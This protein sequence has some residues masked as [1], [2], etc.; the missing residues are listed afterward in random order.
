MGVGLQDLITRAA[1]RCTDEKI[2][3]TPLNKR[4]L[5]LNIIN[6]NIVRLPVFSFLVHGVFAFLVPWC[7]R[8]KDDIRLKKMEY[9]T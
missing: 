6:I 1:G 8:A 9:G 3:I 2:C 7:D 4:K 5:R